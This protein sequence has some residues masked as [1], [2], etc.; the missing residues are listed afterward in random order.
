[1]SKVKVV[2]DMDESIAPEGYRFTGE[3]RYPVEGEY[4]LGEGGKPYK[5]TIDW[6]LEGLPPFILKKLRTRAREGGKFYYV[7]ANLVVRSSVDEGTLADDSSYTSGN[8]FL[9]VEDA[10][11]FAKAVETLGGFYEEVAEKW[12]FL[13]AKNILLGDRG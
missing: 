1:M 3:C 4:Y 8:Y 12:T 6:G 9:N 13:R 11:C 7:A 2:M 5:C 10:E